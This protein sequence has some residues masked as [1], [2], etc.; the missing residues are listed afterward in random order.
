MI[1][2]VGTARTAAY[3]P[4]G[5][6]SLLAQSLPER[7]KLGTVRAYMGELRLFTGW[8]AIATLS[9][10]DASAFVEDPIGAVIGHWSQVR[11]RSQAL[12]RT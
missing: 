1:N 3:C 12:L 2:H 6:S 7:G 11:R 5:H 9:L 4:D 10:R 8:N